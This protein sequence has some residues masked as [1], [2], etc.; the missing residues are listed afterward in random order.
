MMALGGSRRSFA[1]G[2]ASVVLLLHACSATKRDFD[3][4]ETAGGEAGDRSSGSSGSSSVAA[5]GGTGGSFGTTGGTGAS[6]DSPAGAASGAEAGAGGTPEPQPCGGLLC[7]HGGECTGEGASASCDCTGTGYQGATC[8]E[9]ID[10][11]EATPCANG[12]KC[13]DTPGSYSCDCSSAPTYTGNDCDL[14]RF[15]VLPETFIPRDISPDGS[16]VVGADKN[17]LAHKYVDGKAIYLGFLIGDNASA[18]YA[19]SSEGKVIV[20]ASG[21]NFLFDTSKA[22]RW[23]GPDITALEVAEGYTNCT[24]TGV[25]AD[26]RVIG[27]TCTKDGYQVVRWV[28]GVFE[29]LGI[30]DGVETCTDVIVSDDGAV[31]AGRC[32]IYPANRGFVW[33]EGAGFKLLPTLPGAS[34]CVLSDVSADGAAA[35]GQCVSGNAGPGSAYLWTSAGGTTALPKGQGVMNG[36]GV[37]VSAN[38]LRV[39]GADSGAALWDDPQAASTS[40]RD[41]LPPATPGLA[42]WSLGVPIALSADG[43]T[44]VGEGSLQNTTR[45]YIAR[46]DE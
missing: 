6:G 32:S 20:G 21:T 36:Y 22:V 34:N 5:G 26:G 42:N 23:D 39:L 30:A 43:T 3:E 24:A 45:R 28:D 4:E 12:T 46:L 9:N 44:I 11:C 27:G 29:P 10:E 35:V 37:A 13:T 8:D 18:A 2:A 17:T 40:L 14:L 33:S 19:A 25:S 41:L 38:G 31:V 16:V 7:V 15:E 1:V